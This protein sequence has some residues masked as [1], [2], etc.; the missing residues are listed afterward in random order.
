MR[1]NELVDPSG[2]PGC[3]SLGHWTP[4]RLASRAVLACPRNPGNSR[5][6][7][8]SEAG[9]PSLQ[10]HHV[11]WKRVTCKGG[12]FCLS[13]I[14]ESELLDFRRSATTPSTSSRL[15]GLGPAGLCQPYV[16]REE[17]TG[18]SIETLGLASACCDGRRASVL[19]VFFSGAGRI[20]ASDSA[21]RRSAE[22]DS[23]QGAPAHER[24]HCEE[25]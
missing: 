5:G 9:P 11:K 8:R 21:V 18:R 4:L 2:I 23:W 20:A 25:R 3:G 12:F 7:A 17:L 1:R 14:V 10:G 24:A 16:L 13:Q 15:L 22:A 6:T 19:V